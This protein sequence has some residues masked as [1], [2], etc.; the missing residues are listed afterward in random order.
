MLTNCSWATFVTAQPLMIPVRNHKIRNS[1]LYM[2]CRSIFHLFSTHPAQIER[3]QLKDDKQKS[4]NNNNIIQN[5]T[6]Q[7]FSVAELSPE[8]TF[9]TWR[10]QLQGAS[11]RYC[12]QVN[13][14]PSKRASDA[15][16]RSALRHTGS[17]R[18]RIYSP[19]IAG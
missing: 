19:K 1:R 5:I 7:I 9:A 11:V 6:G 15:G 18:H 17:N 10:D 2:I 12:S 16:C 13:T 14:C 4:I 8:K 3:V